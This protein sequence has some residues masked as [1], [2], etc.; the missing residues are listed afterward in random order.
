MGF[1]GPNPIEWPDIESFSRQTGT[2]LMPWEI[3]AL[4]SVDDA[5]LQP[6]A[7]QAA[8]SKDK[9]GAAGMVDV[10][11]GRG[12]RALLRSIVGRGKTKKGG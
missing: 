10:S 12:V 7:K 6:A 4:E 3:E 5:F 8:A 11:D 9:T 1:S 2:R